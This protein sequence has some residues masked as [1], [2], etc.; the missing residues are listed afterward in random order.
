MRELAHMSKQGDVYFFGSD[1][2]EE[3]LRES[4]DK[5]MA[6]RAV[7][8]AAEFASDGSVLMMDK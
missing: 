6:F 8:F 3:A 4:V 7:V 1:I 5:L 2:T